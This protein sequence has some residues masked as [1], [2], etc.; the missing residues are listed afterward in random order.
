VNTKKRLATLGV[1]ATL[2]GGAGLGLAPS[3]SAAI[4]DE[5]KNCQQ[6]SRSVTG[7]WIGTCD[8]TWW[9]AN[10][11]AR[12][13]R[14]YF[15]L[16]SYADADTYRNTGVGYAQSTDGSKKTYTYYCLYDNNTSS[17]SL[18][19]LTL[20]G[21]YPTAHDYRP[22]FGGGGWNPCKGYKG[23]II[24]IDGWYGSSGHIRTQVKY[25]APADYYPHG[26]RAY[27]CTYPSQSQYPADCT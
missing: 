4:Y 24:N 27:E 9:N 5:V 25:N 18:G 22:Q 6:D 17:A 16:I 11:N 8:N 20:G 23:M 12:S 10:P 13:A 26:A 14:L 21:G 19:T 2:L 1:G 15:S 7:I 3:A